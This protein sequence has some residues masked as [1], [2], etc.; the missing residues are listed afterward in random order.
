MESGKGMEVQ[1][2]QPEKE[3]PSKLKSILLY[4]LN[5]DTVFYTACLT[6]PNKIISLE[7]FRKTKSKNLITEK[8]AEL[9]VMAGP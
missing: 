7:V 1:A 6:R 4:F 5:A 3:G 8:K 2:I 9:T